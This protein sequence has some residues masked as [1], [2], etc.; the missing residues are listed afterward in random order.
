MAKRTPTPWRR[1]RVALRAAAAAL[2][3]AVSAVTPAQTSVIQADEPDP[4]V[5]ACLATGHVGGAGPVYPPEE[6]GS[7][8]GGTVRVRM[9]FVNANGPPRATVLYSQAESFEAAVL[10]HIR[11]YRLPCFKPAAGRV[12]F[13]QEFN[14]DR[15]DGRKVAWSAPRSMEEMSPCKA[16]PETKASELRY[17]DYAGRRG[18]QGSVLAQARFDA[19]GQAPTVTILNEADVDGRDLKNV[20]VAH[21]QRSRLIC[22][23]PSGT[24]PKI[25]LQ[26]FRFRLEGAVAPVLKDLTLR[27][28]VG[29]IDKPDRHRVRFDLN[30]MA[31]PFEV[32]LVLYQPYAANP[33]GEVGRS[34]P[35]RHEFLLWLSTVALRIPPVTLKD[36]LGDTIRISVP[37]GSLDLTS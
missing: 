31:C 25:A 17:P 37:C 18:A 21:M 23:E 35:N 16:T 8:S 36:V 32:D 9:E 26:L 27:Q 11:S 28:F 2:C 10:E 22:S 1:L 6:L 29:A 24:W 3:L 19:P 15:R 34:D 12:V 20:A 13:V 33:V 5:A 30:S 7:K 14:F 4:S